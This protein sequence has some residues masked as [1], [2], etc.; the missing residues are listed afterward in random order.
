M[1]NILE[2]STLIQKNHLNPKGHNLYSA[3]F[4]LF[5]SMS[6]QM[7]EID[8]EQSKVQC[9]LLRVMLCLFQS[10]VTMVGHSIIMTAQ[11]TYNVKHE[12]KM[13]AI[14]SE[15]DTYTTS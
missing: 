2:H 8:T 4:H 5:Q 3:V 12:E 10:L 14:I 13:N 11:C 6:K 1:N 7:I 9:V 15:S